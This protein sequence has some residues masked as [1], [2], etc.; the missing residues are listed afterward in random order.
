M[1]LEVPPSADQD[2]G[3]VRSPNYRTKLA[4]PYSKELKIEIGIP[5]FVIWLKEVKHRN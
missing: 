4:I 3:E 1:R 5:L 2:P